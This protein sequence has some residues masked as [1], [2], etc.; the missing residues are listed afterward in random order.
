M[1]SALNRRLSRSARQR[2]KGNMRK[3]SRWGS[4]SFY[5]S[6]LVALPVPVF[7]IDEDHRFLYANPAFLSIFNL[8]SEALIGKMLWDYWPENEFSFFKQAYDDV[9][10]THL[11]AVAEFESIDDGRFSEVT[12]SWWDGLVVGAVT[13]VTE[14]RHRQQAMNDEME[15]VQQLM[16]ELAHLNSIV[17]KRAETDALTG[18]RNR[19]HVDELAER[20]F[21]AVH[22]HDL[23]VSLILIDIDH[24]KHFNDTYGHEQGDRVLCLVADVV[25]ECTGDSE[26][27]ARFGGEEFLLVC[28]DVDIEEAVRR[29]QELVLKIRAITEAPS[30]VAVSIGVSSADRNDTDWHQVLRRAD[31]ALYGAKAMGRDQVVWLTPPKTIDLDQ[32]A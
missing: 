19:R 12:M 8:P 25:R 6:F 18:L 1:G 31:Q 28:P 5:E 13:E 14:H 24:F 9:V 11:A 27:A 4:S 26:M 10:E 29:A 16:R 7:V 17:M 23:E 32:A 15:A 3:D 2:L 21:R 20:I 22:S 30:P